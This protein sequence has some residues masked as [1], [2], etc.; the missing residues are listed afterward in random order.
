M[1]KYTPEEVEQYTTEVKDICAKYKSYGMIFK[2]KSYLKD[3]VEWKT[4]THL[5][6][7]FYTFRTKLYWIV[8]DLTDF[9]RCK[10]PECN[11]PLE[12]KNIDSV[13]R[14]Y[15]DYCCNSCAQKSEETQKKIYST[16]HL[17]IIV[18]PQNIHE[19]IISNISK[20]SN[21]ELA[22]IIWNIK[23]NTARGLAQ[24]LTNHAKP[25]YDEVVNRTSFLLNCDQNR[26]GV[27]ILARLYCISNHITYHP[28]CQCPDCNN[29]TLW[30]SKTMKFNPYCCDGCRA[31]DPMWRKQVEDTCLKKYNTT[32]PSKSP[33]VRIKYRNTCNE[34][35]GTDNYAKSYE[36][37]KKKKHKFHS[38]KYPGLTFDSK[39]EVKVYEF[40]MDNNIQVEYSP[41]IS[42]PYE[43]NGRTF[44]YHPDFLINGKVYEVK[45]DQFFRINKSSGR[46]E[47]ICPYR[48]PEWSDEQYAWVCGKF[49]AKFQCMLANNVSILRRKDIN[50][51]KEV[52]NHGNT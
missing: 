36:Y 39:W 19:T 12:W 1:E 20:V 13:T 37:H 38:G 46:E 51:L 16:K 8:H 45:G 34:K 49:N 31:K 47:M 21:E 17:E 9:P 41:E 28:T 33:I 5:S 30:N 26:I 22:K 29:P 10:N 15:R 27:P 35:Y 42:I 44:T 14:G 4:S 43:Y 48:E 24:Y 6:D 32:N 18:T 3:F 52:F 2:K 23:K 7:P 40:C 25:I 50:N 11:K